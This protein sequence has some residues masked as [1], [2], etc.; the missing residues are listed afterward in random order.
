[1]TLTV[2]QS[3]LLDTFCNIMCNKP[4]IRFC[5]IVN[6]M[7]RLA[8]GSFKDDI[9]PLDNDLQRQMLYMQSKLELS[10]KGEFDDNLGHVNYIVTYRDNVVIICIPSDNQQYHILISAERSSNAQEIVDD[11]AKMFKEMEMRLDRQI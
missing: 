4:K 1:M 2:K 5:G 10:M 7:G 6:S 11:V 8:A 9:L 3:N